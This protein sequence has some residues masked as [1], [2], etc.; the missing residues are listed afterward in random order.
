MK[1]LLAILVL[2]VLLLIAICAATLKV[3][4]RGAKRKFESV[5]EQELS[6][7]SADGLRLYADVAD[8]PGAKGTILMFH[9]YHS[10]PVRDFSTI[11]T[12]YARLGYR[13]VY[14][15]QRAHG[16]SGGHFT[17]LGIKEKED[18]LAWTRCINETYGADA[19]VFLSGVSMGATTVLLAAGSALPAN[20]RGVIADCGFTSPKEILA[21]LLEN[22]YHLPSRLVLPVMSAAIRLSAGYRPDAASTPAAMQQIRIPVLLIHGK[23]DRFVPCEMSVR[24]Q[25][26]AR[27]NCTLLLVEGA[28]HAKSFETDPERY[29]AAVKKFIRSCEASA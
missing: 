14:V 6:I 10:C 27:G 29:L 4:G 9:G 17:C 15:H 16:K 22:K 20:I 8:C 3:T 26:A 19:P 7:L 21:Y 1:M 24:N 12:D 2:I 25:T 5:G 23:A 28:R 13:C 18:C 11:H